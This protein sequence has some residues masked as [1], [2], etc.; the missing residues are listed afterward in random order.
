M[1]HMKFDITLYELPNMPIDINIGLTWLIN[2]KVDIDLKK[3]I[4]YSD[5]RIVEI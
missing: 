3:S 5:N 2:N 4:D 1:P